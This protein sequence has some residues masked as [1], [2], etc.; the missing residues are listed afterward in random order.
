[1]ESFRGSRISLVLVVVVV[2][3][4]TPEHKLLVSGGYFRV[5]GDN[6]PV[7]MIATKSGT[8]PYQFQTNHEES[9]T[10][11]DL[12]VK[13]SQCSSIH[14][15]SVDRDIAMIG[16]LFHDEYK[17]KHV[18][19]EFQNAPEPAYLHLNCL[20]DAIVA[21]DSLSSVATTARCKVIQTIYIASGCDFVSYFVGLG[22]G[23]F[24]NALH[25][26]APFISGSTNSSLHGDLGNT[27][28]ADFEVGLLSFYRLVGCV[29]FAA[30]RSAE[31]EDTES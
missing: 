26:Y 12:H 6:R 22:K 9:D 29:Y 19:I 28:Q 18:Y 8:V 15:R 17:D 25:N 24:Y 11:I 14:I 10:Q 13:D 1:M 27:S 21:D 16:L 23:S 4:F 7:T 2:V 20:H 5:F 3:L 31:R 30:N